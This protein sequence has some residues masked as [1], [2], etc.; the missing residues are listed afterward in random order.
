MKLGTAARLL[1]MLLVVALVAAA[2]GDAGS[3]ATTVAPQDTPLGT[4]AA[5]RATTTTEAPQDTTADT[6]ATADTT[7]ATFPPGGGVDL[8]LFR[9]DVDCGLEG[10]DPDGE[11]EFFSAHYVVDGTLGE[12]CFGEEDPTLILAWELLAS[13]TPGGQLNDLALFG[14]FTGG[15]E[16]E[17]VTLAFVDALDEDGSLYQMSV[18]LDAAD[19]DA[20]ELPLTMA[21]EFSHV[22]TAL[23]F[24]LDRQVDADSCPTY[25]NGEGCYTEG[26]LMAEWVA[27]FWGGGL[28]DEIDP[29]TDP[30]GELGAERCDQNPG[31]LGAYA[32]SSPEEDFAES[33][34]AFVFQLPVG[35]ADLQAKMNWFAQQPG[36]VEFQTRAATA[37]L[38]PLDNNFDVCGLAA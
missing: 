36:L 22:F 18:N 8:S 25:H 21:H 30:T 38:G 28:I 37:G 7:S 32:A 12:V 15:G 3:D 16:D 24:E 35:S 31:F 29:N 13:I 4:T 26:S 33:F 1:G 34:S 9:D 23:P 10:L 20:N 11:T 6:T 19:E 5:T 2:C 14:G 27:T 17:E